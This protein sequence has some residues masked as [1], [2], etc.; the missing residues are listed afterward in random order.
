MSLT[1]A[2]ILSAMAG[3]L[4]V[5]TLALVMLAAY[6]RFGRRRVPLAVVTKIWEMPSGIGPMAGALLSWRPTAVHRLG[7]LAGA[8]LRRNGIRLQMAVVF[9]LGVNGGRRSPGDSALRI[10]A[11]DR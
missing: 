5:I 4:V 10:D 7:V 1:M 2:V 11:T 6:V 8:D 9:G 3:A